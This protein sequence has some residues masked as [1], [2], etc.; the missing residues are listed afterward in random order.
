M[1]KGSFGAAVGCHC[2]GSCP[3]PLKRT[4]IGVGGITL[5]SVSLLF[6]RLRATI[7][8]DFYGTRCW[9]NAGPQSTEQFIYNKSVAQR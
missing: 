4:R 9:S 7:G 8:S 1:K 6:P 3:I 2:C 5:R